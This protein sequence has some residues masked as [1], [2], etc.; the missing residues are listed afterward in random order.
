[1]QILMIKFFQSTSNKT[2]HVLVKME[3]DGLSEKVE[4]ISTKG[5]IKYVIDGYSNLKG[6]KYFPSGVLQSYLAFTSTDT[7][8]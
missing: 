2:N 7:Y 1:M 3:I 4:L 6:A 5:L 8:I